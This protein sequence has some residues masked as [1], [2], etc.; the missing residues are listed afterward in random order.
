MAKKHDDSESKW[1]GV[2]RR[3]GADRR[4]M[5]SSAVPFQE[6]PKMLDGGVIVESAEAEKA[7]AKDAPK[8]KK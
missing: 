1:D 2:E 3:S 4:V 5:P 6:Y 8:D 7:H